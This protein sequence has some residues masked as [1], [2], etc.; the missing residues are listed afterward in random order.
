MRVSELID[1]LKCVPQHYDVRFE[2][3]VLSIDIDG[4]G[5]VNSAVVLTDRIEVEDEE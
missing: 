5:I 2:H 3:G 4:I 1:C